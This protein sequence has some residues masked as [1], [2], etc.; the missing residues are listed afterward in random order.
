MLA[1][2]CEK[3]AVHKFFFLSA[4]S[5][6]LIQDELKA[7]D[8]SPSVRMSHACEAEISLPMVF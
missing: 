6:I 1:A 2:I 7:I 3:L 4:T 5:R 8:E